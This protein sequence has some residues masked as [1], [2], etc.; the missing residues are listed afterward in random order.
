MKNKSLQR[1]RLGVLFT[2]AYTTAIVVLAVLYL[3]A[4]LLLIP[5]MWLG[6]DEFWFAHHIFQYT[7]KIPYR[8][9][10]PYK[11]VLGYY[12]LSLPLYFVHGLFK[13]I[14]FIKYEIALINTLMLTGLALFTHRR[15][16]QPAVFYTLLLLIAN[17]LFLMFA[18]DCR[19]DMLTGWLCL[20]GLLF[21][22]SSRSLTAGIVFGLAFLTSQK[23]LW[24]IAAFNGS[25]AL[26]WLANMDRR[27]ALRDGWRCNSAMLLVIS[28]Y[29]CGWAAVAG[30]K[31]VLHSLFYEAYTQAKISL[32]APG[33][34]MYWQFILRH[35][36]ILFMLLPLTWVGLFSAPL[37]R[38]RL[39]F[40]TGGMINLLF[41]ACYLQFFPYN[42]VLLV[43][44]FFGIY[45]DFFSWIF[46]HKM[47]LVQLS[48]RQLQWFFAGYL[49]AL[50]SFLICL[51][52]TAQYWP[53]CLI[54]LSVWHALHHRRALSQ[55][56]RHLTLGIL[57]WCGVYLPLAQFGAKLPVKF[58]LFQ[59]QNVALA[60][61]VVGD[62]DYIAGLLLFYNKDQVLPGFENLITPA[63]HY[64]ATAD[65]VLM[66]TLI[67][68]LSITPKT[69]AEMLVD[70]AA[71]PPKVWI[72][73]TR[74]GA[75]PIAVLVYLRQNYRHYW[76][77]IYT[78][79]PTIGKD[80]QAFTI[81]F[82]G[83]YVVETAQPLI[84]DDSQ[85]A[86]NASVTLTQGRHTSHALAPYR[87]RL[88]L[89]PP[90]ALVWLNPLWQYDCPRCLNKGI[91]F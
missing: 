60:A 15:F 45:A 55:L 72:N 69:A 41:I 88:Q 80:Q 38:S 65:K 32:Y 18:T 57:L 36:P 40:L 89:P 22:V 68:S 14:F 20:V 1:G 37:P 13:P 19:V 67:A 17:Q 90:A 3:A 54:P 74:I 87:L 61:Q 31:V 27:R 50:I 6:P 52:L 84:L 48:Q 76:S 79:A 78:Y 35:G 34:G 28:L 47:V 71:K 82:A 25:L 24:Y 23:T 58:A 10:L 39:L 70:L 12:L 2:P 86:A 42:S 66:P 75:L 83:N 64:A 62:S 21:L 56:A 85:V 8:D 73:N 11:S 46:S 5:Y 91:I 81:P 33:Y 43:P 59:Q 7:Q 26:T 63:L 29:I 77:N 30:F 53:V 9:F 49:L 51:G 4:Q 16:S 44:I